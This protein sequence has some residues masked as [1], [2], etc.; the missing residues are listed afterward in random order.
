LYI[1]LDRFK[2]IND[3]LGHA[4][5][6]EVMRALAIRLES[7]IRGEDM[8][9]RIG[10]DEFV[11]L[12]VGITQPAGAS[13]LADRLMRI[14][15]EPYDIGGSHITCQASI[16]VAIAPTDADDW[17]SLLAC[18]I[19]AV[20]KAKAEGRNTVRFFEAG[21]DSVFRERRQ[22]E[23]DLRRAL[24]IKV[25]ELAY[26][27]LYSFQNGSL[28][29]FEALLRWPTGW[30]PK[31][32]AVFVPV[33]EESGLIVPIGAWVLETACRTAADWQ[34][35]LKVAVNLSPVQ[36]RHGDVVAAVQKALTLSGLDPARLELEVTESLW[37]QDT[38]VVLEQ[39][40]RLR[41]M[42]ISIALDDFGTGYS[43][44][45][46]LWKFP[47]DKVKIDRSFVMEME[48]DPKAAAIVRT[49]V[50]LGR[51]LNLTITAEGVETQAQARDLREAGYDQA[52][53]YLFGRPLSFEQANELVNENQTSSANPWGSHPLPETGSRPLISA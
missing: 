3:S 53:G 14:L 17:D 38:D 40:M 37:I 35:P 5:G 34:E 9:A 25:F 2:A 24:D 43:S 45:T 10:G 27:P 20:Y 15:A 4:V 47:F 49:I 41:E 22:L 52:Q 51:T 33:A 32:P 36:F 18:A 12:Q 13:S 48:S 6:D 39:L 31:S 16:G 8:A 46:Y 7:A 23:A 29:G 19:A 11:I 50:A 26:Q 21:M 1:D 44:L 30:K 28:L 42:G